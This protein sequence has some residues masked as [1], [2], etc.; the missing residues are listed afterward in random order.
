MS[1][2]RPNQR[3]YLL[4][5]FNALL[6][7][8]EPLTDKTY[9]SNYSLLGGIQ[10]ALH[11]VSLRQRPVCWYVCR[12]WGGLCVLLAVSRW[13][14][15]DDDG[16]VETV[17]LGRLNHITINCRWWLCTRVLVGALLRFAFFRRMISRV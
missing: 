10:Y 11:L 7:N 12:C 5:R 2:I 14:A 9:L 13:L 16:G 4:F 1:F 8:Y 3:T 15:I 17:C 6:I